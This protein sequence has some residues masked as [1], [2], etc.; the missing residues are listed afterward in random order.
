MLIHWGVFLLS[1]VGIVLAGIRLAPYGVAMGEHLRI[2][3]GW[4]GLIFLATLTSIPEMTATVTAASIDAP[5]IALGNAFGS[6]LFNV[7]IVAV[8]DLLLLRSP[9]T[10]GPFLST[11]RSYHTISGGLAVLLTALAVIGIVLKPQGTIFGVSPISVLILIGYCAGVFVLLRAEKSEV[12]EPKAEESNL[13]LARAV[14]GFVLCGAVIVVSGIFLV[15]ASKEISLATNLSAS[16][17][18]AILV[19]IVTSLPELT[20]SIGALRIGARDMIVGNLFGS[21]MFNILTVFFAD[22][23]FRRGSIY[24]GLSGGESDQLVVASC[25]IVLT[26]IAVTAIAARS[27]RRIF[28]IGVDSACLLAAYLAATAV[29]IGRGIQL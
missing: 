27:T 9:R 18:G 4:I 20:T 12:G 5:N 25:G 6:N 16:L 7:V 3:Q 23:A 1:A 15:R 29:I 13:S 19:A 24:A 26:A 21:N 11:V 22:V 14:V 2:G 17:M 10:R 8:M 28:G